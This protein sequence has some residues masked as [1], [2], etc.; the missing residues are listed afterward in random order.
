MYKTYEEALEDRTNEDIIRPYGNGFILI[1]KRKK[2]EVKHDCKNNKRY[3]NKYNDIDN[4]Y[5]NSNNIIYI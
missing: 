4:S 2:N 1:P 5:T 3:N